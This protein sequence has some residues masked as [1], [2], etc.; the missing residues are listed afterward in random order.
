MLG[1]YSS[2]IHV[3]TIET[4]VKEAQFQYKFSMLGHLNSVKDIAI[5][6]VLAKSD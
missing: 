2:Q 3:Y 5:S 1:G 4:V 6:D